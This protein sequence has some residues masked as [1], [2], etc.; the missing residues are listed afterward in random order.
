MSSNRPAVRKHLM[1][2]G[3]QRPQR[4][5]AMSLGTVQKWVLSSLAALTIM[6]MSA[7]LVVAAA[8]SDRLDS[9][10]GLLVI[11]AAFGVIA[12]I[13]ALLIHQH[14]LFSPWLLLGLVP[15]LVGVY[16][17]FLR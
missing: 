2:P 17:V 15:S 11:A 9:K 8:F 12:I 1:T 7:G 6:H 14:R 13:A 4:P 5:D 16:F 3:Q 10:I